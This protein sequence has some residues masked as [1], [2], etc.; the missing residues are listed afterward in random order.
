VPTGWTRSKQGSIVYFRSKGRVL[1]IDQSK[2]PKSDPVAD[3]REQSAY[4]VSHGDFPGY[5][6]IRIAP[7]AYWQKAADWE[8]TFTDSGVRQHVNNRGLVVSKSQAYGIYWQTRDSSWPSLR[9][10]LDLVFASFRPA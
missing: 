8:F 6:R 1:G 2:H 3:W 10:D 9:P 7:V 5:H 4:R